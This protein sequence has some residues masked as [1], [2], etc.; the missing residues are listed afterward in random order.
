VPKPFRE[1]RKA[2]R[3]EGPVGGR[4]RIFVFGGPK[5]KIFPLEASRRSEAGGPS[6][7]EAREPQ[8]LASRLPAF[9]LFPARSHEVARSRHRS[10]CDSGCSLAAKMCRIVR[11]CGG[12]ATPDML[13]VNSKRGRRR[14]R[15]FCRGG[16]RGGR[17]AGRPS[18]RMEG[19]WARAGRRGPIADHQGHDGRLELAIL[20]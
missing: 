11:S 13:A 19:R 1:N 9:L 16:G 15:W 12:A 20:S 14:R 2:G 10:F 18:R 5:P 7:R 4:E 8:S 17:R 3:R 6:W